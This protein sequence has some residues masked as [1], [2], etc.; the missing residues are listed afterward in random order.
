MGD[1]PNDEDGGPP[2]GG[3]WNDGPSKSSQHVLY[4]IGTQDLLPQHL[5]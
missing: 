5:T 3:P 2:H 4:P 1:P